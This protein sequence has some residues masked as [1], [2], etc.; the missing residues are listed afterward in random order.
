MGGAS[1]GPDRF[2]S[3]PVPSPLSALIPPQPRRGA[4]DSET[5]VELNI[6]NLAWEGYFWG[7]RNSVWF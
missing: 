2:L 5:R 1:G 4:R 3:Q 6:W 7:C